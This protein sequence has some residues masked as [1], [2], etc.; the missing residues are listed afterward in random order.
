MGKKALIEEATALMDQGRA[1]EALPL[2]R[3]V[4]REYPDDDEAWYLMG[5]AFNQK[6]QSAQA[7]QALREHLRRSPQSPKGH[8]QLA[9][10]LLSQQRYAEAIDVL[11]AGV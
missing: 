7:E 9:V 2:L 8:A 3:V 11:Q 4:T 1:R 6:Q 10:A 5:W